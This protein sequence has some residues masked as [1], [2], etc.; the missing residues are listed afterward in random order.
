MFIMV[1]GLDGS[2]K[3]TVTRSWREMLEARGKKI[4]DAVAFEKTH[5][6]IPK[7]SDVNDAEIIISA[8]PTY[9]GAGKYVRDV[10][11]KTDSGAS[12]REI[13]EGFSNQ[14][15]ELY[16]ALILPA[17]ARGLIIIQ[18]RGITSS[19]C[20]QAGMSV[21]ITE[22]FVA[23]LAGNQIAIE[24]APDIVVLCEVPPDVAITRL[25]GRMDKTDDAIFERRDHMERV[26]ARFAAES[27]KQY[28]TTH[29]TQFIPFNAN[30]PIALAI[31]SAQR[32]LVDLLKN[33]GAL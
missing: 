23:S 18:D 4:F 30:Q 13:T 9:A 16:T 19:L 29:G 11:I 25:T 21:E 24:N 1:D 15:L 2:G 33:A 26:A 32:L 22:A 5:N 28:L 14:R 17:R 7:M 12:A 31:Q 10:L 27:W 20:Y 8:E 3:S 6:Q